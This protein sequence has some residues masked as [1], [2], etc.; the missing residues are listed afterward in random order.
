MRT[1]TKGC[2]MKKIG[3]LI[4]VLLS[5]IFFFSPASAL[6]LESLKIAIDAQGASWVPKERPAKSVAGGQGGQGLGLIKQILTPQEEAQAAA[7]VQAFATMVLP[8]KLDWRD[9]GGNYVTP[10]RNQG[11]CGS[12]WAF[13]ATAAL[14]SAQL[15]ALRTPGV[16]LNL[17]EQIMLSCSGAGDCENGGYVGGA[18]D[19]ILNTGLPPES[20][21]PYT[22]KDGTCSTAAPHW[23]ESAYKINDWNYVAYSSPTASTLKAALLTYGPLVTT[24]DVYED[25]YNHYSSGIYSYVSGNYVGGHAVL[26]VGYDDPG[27]YFIVKNSWSPSW[28]ES[29]YFRIA[30][31]ELSSKVNFGDYTISYSVNVPLTVTKSGNASNKGTVTA[32]GLVCNG[33]TCTGSYAPGTSVTLTA[34]A[35]T[36]SLFAGWDGCDAASGSTCTITMTGQKAASAAFVLP[37]KISVNPGS[38]NFGSVK[39]DEQTVKQVTVK[40]LGTADLVVNSVVITGTNASEVSVVNH[41]AQAVAGSSCLIDV[42]LT[43]ASYGHK[44]A[45]LHIFSNDPKKTAG[46]VIKLAADAVPPKISVSPMNVNFGGVAVGNTSVPKTITIKNTGLSELA[47]DSPVKSGNDPS[48]FTVSGSCTALTAMRAAGAPCALQVTF[49]PGTTGARSA[50][51]EIGSNDPARSGTPLTIKLSGIGK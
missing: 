41:C 19:F 22:A 31:S 29:G 25:F 35:A 11:S 48:D 42:S 6:D 14:E 3:S 5:T 33:N 13:A 24:F 16:D 50:H 44:T 39:T 36:G 45:Q 17:A 47:V 34:D 15:R 10:V 23:M 40:N 46:S 27:Q 4:L 26:L 38:L 9:N 7:H 12:C 49:T 32:S 30:Y 43:P 37:P 1:I 18:A 28:G 2:C 20:F 21:Y 8:G 51:I